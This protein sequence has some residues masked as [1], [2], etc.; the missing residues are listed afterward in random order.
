MPVMLIVPSIHAYPTASRCTLEHRTPLPRQLAHI[1]IRSTAP[2]A[3]KTLLR[4]RAGWSPV[5]PSTRITEERARA[6]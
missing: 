3:P 4:H 6:G 1:P 5:Q 2:Q